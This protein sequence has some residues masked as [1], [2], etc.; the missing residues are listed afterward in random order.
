[1]DYIDYRSGNSALQY[2]PR[3][4]RLNKSEDVSEFNDLIGNPDLV[5][6]DTLQRQLAELVAIRN[7][8]RRFS[9][10]EIKNEINQILGEKGFHEYG[11]W[12]YYSWSNRLIHLVDEADFYELRTSRN[13]YKIT[14]EEQDQLKSKKIG[15]VGLSVGNAIAVTMAMER[16]SGEIRLADFDTLDLTNLNRIRSGIHQIGQNKAIITAREISE[17][18]PFLEVKVFTDGLTT[19]NIDEFLTEGGK[20]DLVADECDS[21]EIKLL[22]RKK[23]KAFGIPVIMETSDRGMLDIERFDLE[24][25]RPVFHGRLSVFGPIPEGPIPPEL[26]MQILMSVVDYSKVSV[27]MRESYGEI[28]K[29]ITTWPQL[30]SSVILGGGSTTDLARRI[31]LGQ[32]THSGRIYVDT[33]ALFHPDNISN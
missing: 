28:G 25:E 10:E 3:I 11:V 17:I 2:R 19:E 30:A 32:H 29:S 12:V 22:L 20:L 31:L 4:F 16:I 18:D 1:M 21:L 7:P 13:Q 6:L 33:E 27:R 5:I 15:V 24:P 23:A 14:R 9:D 8:T 26:R